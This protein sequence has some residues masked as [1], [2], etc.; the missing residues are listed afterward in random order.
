MVTLRD[1]AVQ[2]GGHVVEQ[3]HVNVVEE[4]VD[5]LHGFD[6]HGMLHLVIGMW[7][8]FGRSLWALR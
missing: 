4:L 5:H 3:V 2:L 7:L 6:H 8:G 1:S